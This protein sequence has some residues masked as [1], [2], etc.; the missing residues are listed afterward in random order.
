MD[1]RKI[2][3]GLF[4]IAAFMALSTALLLG[5]DDGAASTTSAT[6]IPGQEFLFQDND[7]PVVFFGDDATA[8][9][10]FST[11]IETYTL[12]RFPTWKITFRNTG[13][14]DDKILGVG[15][16]GYSRDQDIRRDVEALRPQMVLVNYGVNDAR[17]GQAS[18]QNFLTCVNILSRDLPRVGVNRAAFI[19]ANP[20]EGSSRTCPPAV[21][22]T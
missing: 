7:R 22:T 18:Y 4:L 11:L 5:A 16:R 2:Q 20:E 15:L 14:E 3:L 1:N 21:I 12:S 10:M 17:G 13:W 9:R 8:Q 6:S 19:S